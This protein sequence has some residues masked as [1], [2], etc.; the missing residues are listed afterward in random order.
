[1]AGKNPKTRSKFYFKIV[2]NYSGVWNNVPYL[3]IFS[4]KAAH[5]RE[6]YF[7]ARTEVRWSNKDFDILGIYYSICLLECLT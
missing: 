1:M 2:Y 6:D 4:C 3:S 5:I 7:D